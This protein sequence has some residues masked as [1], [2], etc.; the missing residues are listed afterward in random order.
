MG[1]VA[2]FVPDDIAENFEPGTDHGGHDA[3]DGRGARYLVWSSDPDPSDTRTRTDYAF[4]LRQ[5]TAPSTWCTIRTSSASF[6][7]RFGSRC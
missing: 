6:R 4:L 1:G 5:A 7:G 3:P 2:V